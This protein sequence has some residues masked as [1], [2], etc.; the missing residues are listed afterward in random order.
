MKAVTSALRARPPVRVYDDKDG[1]PQASVHAMAFDHKGYLWVGTQD[2]AA[3][4]NGRI[5]TVVDMPQ[6]TVSNLVQ[7]I[8]VGADGSLWFGTHRGGLSRLARGEWTV[9]DTSS[10][11]PSDDVWS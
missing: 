9:W 8:L 3:F 4:Y 6:R 5:W 2:G 1:L 7:A 11:L 10:G